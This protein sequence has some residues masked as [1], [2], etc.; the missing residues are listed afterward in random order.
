MMN[1]SLCVVVA[2]MLMMRVLDLFLYSLSF[3]LRSSALTH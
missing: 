1:Q 3:G 2:S